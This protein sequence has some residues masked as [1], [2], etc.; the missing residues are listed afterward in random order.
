MSRAGINHFIMPIGYVEWELENIKTGLVT[1]SG[2]S[3]IVV[4]YARDRLAQALIGTSVTYPGFISVG[5]G[6]TS[7]SAADTGLV[8]LSQYDGA[9]DAK[10]FTSKSVKS[11]Y[12]ARYVTQFTSGEANIT[13]RE[14]GLFDSANAGNMWARVTVNITKTS[15][16]VLT[17]YWNITFDRSSGVA[18][19]TGASISATGTATSNDKFTATFAS[20][21]TVVM[22][23]NNSGN[24]LYYKIN[25]DLDAAKP[26]VDYDGILQDNE[27]VYFIEEEISIST[28]ALFSAVNNVGVLPIND[29]AIVGW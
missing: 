1:K 12:T 23:H 26:P 22:L 21:V 13:I 24:E 16:E 4:N 7:P 6:T 27:R 29:F 19:K 28:I 2:K 14:L 5:T 20:A 8:T 15:S 3:N 17:I 18:I 10:A 25:E 11:I 9:N